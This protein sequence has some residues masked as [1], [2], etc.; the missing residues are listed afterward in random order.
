MELSVGKLTISCSEEATAVENNYSPLKNIF[1]NFL[2]ESVMTHLGIF[3]GCFLFSF[4][5]PE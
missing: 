2:V 4:F 1:S 5:F 3:E